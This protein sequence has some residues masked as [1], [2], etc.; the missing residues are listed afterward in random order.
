MREFLAFRGLPDFDHLK[1]MVQAIWD[2]NLEEV[3]VYIEL[4]SQRYGVKI[5][6]PHVLDG[7]FSA[8]WQEET[9]LRVIF[10]GVNFGFIN[11]VFDHWLVPWKFLGAYD[12]SHRMLFLVKGIV[13]V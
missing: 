6:V 2:V 1:E 8:E 4:G 9:E 13:D 12:E 11:L 7:R 10:P 5:S 3:D